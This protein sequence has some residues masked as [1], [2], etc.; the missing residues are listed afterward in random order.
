MRK[1]LHITSILKHTLTNKTSQHSGMRS[2]TN[3]HTQRNTQKH[4]KSGNINIGSAYFISCKAWFRGRDPIERLN[5]REL[6]CSLPGC[7][8]CVCVLM[9]KLYD[10]CILKSQMM[11]V[12]VCECVCAVLAPSLPFPPTSPC[13]CVFHWIKNTFVCSCLLAL[14]SNKVKK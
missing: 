11:A 13:V 14:P 6:S 12:C 9:N 1:V 5:Q 8:R 3:T 7:L 10:D 4:P 2:H